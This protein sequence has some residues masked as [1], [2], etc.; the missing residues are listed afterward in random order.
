MQNVS[1]QPCRSHW[2]VVLQEL[3]LIA[4][5]TRHWRIVGCS[6]VN[7]K[8]LLDAFDWA[9]EDIQSRIFMLN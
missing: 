1:Q 2:P 7:G 9:V 5:G 6:A 4:M 3:N 8:G